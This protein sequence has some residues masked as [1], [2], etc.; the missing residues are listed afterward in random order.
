MEKK[1]KEKINKKVLQAINLAP[2]ETWV[3]KIVDIHPMKQITIASIVQA[4]V[5][6]LMLGTFWITSKIILL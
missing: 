3:E 2:S 1:T 5:F 6:G 4:T